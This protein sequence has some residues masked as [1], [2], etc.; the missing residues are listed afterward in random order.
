MPIEVTC[1]CGRGLKAPDQYAGRKGRCKGC[2]ATLLIPVPEPE[3]AAVQPGNGDGAEYETVADR[4]D[5][6]A[7]AALTKTIPTDDG[8]DDQGDAPPARL[9]PSVSAPGQVKM[10]PEPWYYQF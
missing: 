2:G 4:D 3:P 6:F 7:V 8:D 10:P 1:R 9:A 5:D